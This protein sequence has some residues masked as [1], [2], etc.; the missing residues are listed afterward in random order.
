M[1]TL[2][3][4]QRD[5]GS[6]AG[7]NA[8]PTLPCDSSADCRQ[9]DTVRRWLHRWGEPG[10]A[11]LPTGPLPALEGIPGPPFPVAAL[12]LPLRCLLTARLVGALLCPERAVTSVC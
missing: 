3:D 7:R 2:R 10:A 1:E 12:R 4:S 6:P 9:C 11:A 5:L 8:P